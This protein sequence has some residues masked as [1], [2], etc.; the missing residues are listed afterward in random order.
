MKES[1]LVKLEKRKYSD[2]RQYLI[3]A[4][5]NRRK[6][7]RSMAIE[8]KGGKCEQC[9]YYRCLEALEFHH[10]DP[11][12]KD[13]NISSRGY[14]RSWKRVQE[15]LDK[16]VMLCANCHRE[17]HAKLAALSGNIKMKSGLIQ[18]TLN[19]RNVKGNPEL[20]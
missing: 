19:Y 1:K 12:K 9:G 16:C 15:E 18:G 20:V 2:R 10:A 3:N 14:T 17:T 8:Y 13:F 5:R 6:K 7:I 4:V 11:T